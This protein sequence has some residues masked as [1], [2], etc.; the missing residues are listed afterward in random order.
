M[1]VLFLFSVVFLYFL[2]D[3]YFT[4]VLGYLTFETL[5]LG[6]LY[7]LW[8]AS[9][10][11]WIFICS[12]AVVKLKTLTSALPVD[13]HLSSTLLERISFLQKLLVRIVSIIFSF[14]ELHTLRTGNIQTDIT[15]KHP[16]E[17]SSIGP[18]KLFSETRIIWQQKAI[19]MVI[20]AGGVN[21]LVGKVCFS[22]VYLLALSFIWLAFTAFSKFS[23]LLFYVFSIVSISDLVH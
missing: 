10:L 4:T 5:K 16:R 21:W 11:I 13:E 23:F 1:C 9:F 12:A 14:M 7:I 20:E 18:R 15:R 19:V 8:P 2:F 6:F 22:L 3:C 17:F